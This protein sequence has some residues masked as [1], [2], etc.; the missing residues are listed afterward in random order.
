MSVFGAREMPFLAMTRVFPPAFE[1]ALALPMPK[2]SSERAA[3]TVPC[4]VAREGA[5]GWRTAIHGRDFWDSGPRQVVPQ[6]RRPA[7][8]CV[9]DWSCGC[10]S[11]KAL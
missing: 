9:R 7:T 3:G 2:S 10:T 8:R 5:S 1:A 6:A 4:E 11:A